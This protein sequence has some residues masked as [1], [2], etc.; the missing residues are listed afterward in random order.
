MICLSLAVKASKGLPRTWEDAV[1]TIDFFGNVAGSIPKLHGSSTDLIC[2]GR[3]AI[4]RLAVEEVVVDEARAEE[5]EALEK[6][7]K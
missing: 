6:M 5:V 3:E 1:V 2:E 7:W 4:I